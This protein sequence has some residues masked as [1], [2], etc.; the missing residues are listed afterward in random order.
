MHDAFR[1]RLAVLEEERK[2]QNEPVRIVNVVFVGADGEEVE[3]NVAEGPANFVCYR[4][5]DEELG[6]FRR[7]AAD[8]CRATCRPGPTVLVFKRGAEKRAFV[9]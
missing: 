5:E 8:E 2:Q 7:R 6:S 9:L 3:S 4:G 1:R